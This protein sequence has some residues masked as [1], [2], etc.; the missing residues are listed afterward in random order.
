M[1][2]TGRLAYANARTR[3]MRS[4][5]FGPEMLTRLGGARRDG[6][7]PAPVMPEPAGE[8]DRLDDLRALA[9][10]EF[11]E[12]LACYKTILRSYPSGQSLFLTLLRFHEVENLKL[13]WRALARAHSFERWGP[14]WRELGQLQSIDR[15]RC[16]HRTSLADLV[17]GLLDSPYEVV[18]RAV[19][20]AHARD[21]SAAELAIDRWASLSL[22]KAAHDLPPREHA[23]R[24]LALALVRE[25]DLNWLRRGVGTFGLSTNAVVAGLAVLSDEFPRQELSRLATW[26]TADGPLGTGAWPRPWRRIAGIAADWDLLMMAVRRAR[27]EACQR[28]FLGPP[29]CLAPAAALLLLK[30]EEVRSVTAI[31]ESGVTPR[32]GG[33]LDRVMAASALGTPPR[34]P[35]WGPR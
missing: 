22:A 21:L 25:R 10:R 13:V 2:R 29:Y 33:S 8:F 11:G 26:T 16:R 15:E 12:L 32:P 35:R 31:L 30:E 7:Q 6:A 28:A 4:R 9:A 14:L 1:R 20:R 19:L 27:R 18:S 5:L 34:V 24:D 17:E 23:A 3:A